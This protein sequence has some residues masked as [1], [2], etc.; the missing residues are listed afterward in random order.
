MVATF[1]VAQLRRELSFSW[2]VIAFWLGFLI[3]GMGLVA[4]CWPLTPAGRNGEDG[5]PAAEGSS[6]PEDRR[7]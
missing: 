2:W 7:T 6:P 5:V 1:T 4:I 3:L